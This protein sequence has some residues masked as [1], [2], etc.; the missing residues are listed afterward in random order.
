VVDGHTAGVIVIFALFMAFWFYWAARYPRFLIGIVAGALTQVL[1]IG[2]L[3]LKPFILLA[4]TD[5]IEGYE[6]QVRILGIPKATST[7]QP[8]Y[9]IYK[10]APYRLL[11]VLAGSFI[12]YIWTIFPVPITEG[13]VLRQDVGRSLFLLAKYLSSVTATVD[14]RIHNEEGD[15]SIKRSPG[16]R[17]QEIRGKLLDEQVVLI[18]SMQ[19]NLVDMD[20]EPPFGGDFPK[21]TYSTIINEIQQSVLQQ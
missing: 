20:W 12:A 5:Y 16:R 9:P 17:L 19:Q 4:S 8:Y 7:G 14:Q 15:M 3:T 2:K 18:N 10:L 1:I 11:T 6:L 13:S 21:Q